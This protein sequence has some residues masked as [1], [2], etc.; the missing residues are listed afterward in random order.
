[1][2]DG[3]PT[4]EW[5]DHMRTFTGTARELVDMLTEGMRMGGVVVETG[6]EFGRPIREVYLWTGGWSGCETIISH[7]ERTFFWFAWWYQSRRGGGF[8]FH[9]PEDQWDKP[10]GAWPFA[11]MSADGVTLE[12]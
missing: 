7:L 1:M 11:T 8:W 3:Y 10:M 12:P 6:E 4:D 9:V 5:L 2:T